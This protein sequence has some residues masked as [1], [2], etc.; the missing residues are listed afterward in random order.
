MQL[1]LFN[2]GICVGIKWQK[3]SSRSVAPPFKSTY[4]D[5]LK[6]VIYFSYNVL[7]RFYCIQ[8]NQHDSQNPDDTLLLLTR[9]RTKSAASDFQFE[10]DIHIWIL[11]YAKQTSLEQNVREIRALRTEI[12]QRRKETCEFFNI[13]IFKCDDDTAQ[14]GHRNKLS[15]CVL[16]RDIPEK[17]HRCR[18]HFKSLQFIPILSTRGIFFKLFAKLH[19]IHIFPRGLQIV[20]TWH[21][22]K[23]PPDVCGKKHW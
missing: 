7:I 9:T 10:V 23:I 17:S 3:T 8:W 19:F 20:M 1:D 2:V 14:T 6:V 11:E 22:G 5:K 21:A 18:D 16:W 15:Y 4:K 12:S 13:K